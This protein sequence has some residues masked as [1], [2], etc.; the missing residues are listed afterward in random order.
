MSLFWFLHQRFILNQH[1]NSK[2]LK[3][4]GESKTETMKTK[5]EQF[6][7]NSDNI[8]VSILVFLAKK[9]NTEIRQ[10]PKQF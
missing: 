9:G 6:L 4:K 2:M 8:Y 3:R 5:N 10:R 1:R 7:T